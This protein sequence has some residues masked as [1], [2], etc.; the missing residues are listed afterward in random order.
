M[1]Y[2][3]KVGGLDVN[4]LFDPNNYSNGGMCPQEDK[5]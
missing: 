3:Q 4:L 5:L 2:Q 1:T